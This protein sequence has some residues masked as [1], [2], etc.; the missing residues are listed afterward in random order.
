MIHHGIVATIGVE[1]EAVNG[2]RCEVGGIIR[3]GEAARFGIVISGGKI[4][5]PKAVIVVI[6]TVAD[7]ICPAERAYARV[8]RAV[9][10]QN[11]ACAPSFVLIVYHNVAAVVKKNS[12]PANASA[13]KITNQKDRVILRRRKVD[14]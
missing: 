4:I 2:V 1:V 8:L 9:G 5:E 7:G 3:R 14:K 10:V 6:P 11:L 12:A 13:E